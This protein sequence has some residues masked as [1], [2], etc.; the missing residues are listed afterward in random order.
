MTVRLLIDTQG[1]RWIGN[2]ALKEYKKVGG[3][4]GY[5]FYRAFLPYKQ[6]CELFPVLI[7]VPILL[8][9]CY[10]ARVFGALFNKTK[11]RRVKAEMKTLAKKQAD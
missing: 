5:F 6:M 4:V 3:K 9:F 1:S 7:K 8:P 11:R 10:V 2:H